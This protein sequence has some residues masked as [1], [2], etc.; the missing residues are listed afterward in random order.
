[1]MRA[2]PTATYDESGAITGPMEP[3]E[4]TFI[5]PPGLHR[6]VTDQHETYCRNCGLV[7]EPYPVCQ[8]DGYQNLLAPGDLPRLDVRKPGPLRLSYALFGPGSRTYPPIRDRHFSRRMVKAEQ[9][10]LQLHAGR[11]PAAS[12]RLLLT[13]TERL[14]DK[15]FNLPVA[16]AQEVQ[17]SIERLA[18]SPLTRGFSIEDVVAGT[19]YAVLR[20]SRWKIA[21][22]TGEICDA[23]NAREA[24]AIRVNYKIARY[25]RLPRWL[26][27]TLDF[28]RYF[29][30]RFNLSPE[31]R[32]EVTE[33]FSDPEITGEQIGGSPIGMVA[34]GIWLIVRRAG[35]GTQTGVARKTGIT[36]VSVRTNAKELERRLR[37]AGRW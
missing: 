34:G 19:A 23:I 20:S 2:M 29:E 14:A 24:R 5:C 16:A 18:H 15:G 7:S 1:M 17:A 21:I 28:F 31:Q 32:K 27:G 33:W 3:P 8:N 35:N 30:P 22:P 12:V 36:E 13:L 10:A 4:P 26:P 11:L 9:R 37:E 6:P 25:L